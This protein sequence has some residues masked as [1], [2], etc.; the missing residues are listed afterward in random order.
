MPVRS[1]LQAAAPARWCCQRPVQRVKPRQAQL[2]AAQPE[3]PLV[4]AWKARRQAPPER[5]LA[6]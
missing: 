1:D 4:A 5:E 3:Q 2:P 6:P